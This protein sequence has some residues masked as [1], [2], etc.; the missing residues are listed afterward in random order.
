M[1]YP[2][3][4]LSF[5]PMQLP[6]DNCFAFSFEKKQK[7]TAL[8][9]SCRITRLAARPADIS[10]GILPLQKDDNLPDNHQRI[11][12]DTSHPAGGGQSGA[13]GNFGAKNRVQKNRGGH[14][15]QTLSGR[16]LPAPRR[17][18]LYKIPEPC[19]CFLISMV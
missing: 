7:K 14:S 13:P 17:S 15:A 18:N 5:P 1:E 16:P 8:S 3:S 10:C 19:H 12:S 11:F 9:C 6:T 4:P 2:W